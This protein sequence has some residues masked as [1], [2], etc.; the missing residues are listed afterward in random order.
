MK[1]SKKREAFNSIQPSASSF[2][3]KSPSKTEQRNDDVWDAENHRERLSTLDDGNPLVTPSTSRRV[4][5]VQPLQ[6]VL[7][8]DQPVAVV[9]EHRSLTPR[10]R[11]LDECCPSSDIVPY[12]TLPNDMSDRFTQRSSHENERSVMGTDGKDIGSS[13]STSHFI[14]SSRPFTMF[15]VSASN[16]KR[17]ASS[18]YEIIRRFQCLRIMTLADIHRSRGFWMVAQ[19]KRIQVVLPFT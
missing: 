6:T 11:R 7:K 16:V 5:E 8:I 2:G 14:T 3:M 9:D 18:D 1:T 15:D 4:N 17:S 13:S 10:K 19:R 12:K